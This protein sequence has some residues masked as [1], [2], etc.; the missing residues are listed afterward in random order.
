MP[1]KGAQRGG[2]PLVGR[3]GIWVRLPARAQALNPGQSHPGMMI[4]VFNHFMPPRISIA[5]VR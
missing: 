2:R 3:G 5:W 4:D 1:C